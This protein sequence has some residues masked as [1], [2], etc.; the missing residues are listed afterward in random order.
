MISL[1]TNVE[2]PRKPTLIFE[3]PLL[4]KEFQTP[5]SGEL[6]GDFRGNAAGS[7]CHYKYAIRKEDSLANIVGNEHRGCMLRFRPD[8]L[9]FEIHLLAGDFVQAPEGLI[10]KED[11]RLKNQAASDG[12]TP[13]HTTGQLCRSR[14]LEFAKADQI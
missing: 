1:A 13:R 2:D 6:D 4:L 5:R 7:R 9:E 8:S 12:H 10:Q 11:W 14:L 3:E